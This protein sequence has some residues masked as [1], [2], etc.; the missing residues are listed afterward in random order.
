[1]GFLDKFKK[2]KE[3]KTEIPVPQPEGKPS[4]EDIRTKLDDVPSTDIPPALQEPA[5]IE[6][7]KAEDF[8]TPT[9]ESKTIEGLSLPEFEKEDAAKLPEQIPFAEISSGSSDSN[10]SASSTPDEVSEE[11]ALP[12]SVPEPAEVPMAETPKESREVEDEIFI[13]V[14][15]YKE[16]LNNIANVKKEVKNSKNNIDD[17]VKNI[18]FENQDITKVKESLS[19]IQKSIIKVDDELFEK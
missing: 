4:T 19:S 13:K 18:N 8:G 9:E 11:P 12:E 1:M 15:D 6:E 7:P 10:L 2:K 17:I 5:K 3:E 16:I 14:S